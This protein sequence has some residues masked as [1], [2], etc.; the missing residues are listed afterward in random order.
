MNEPGLIEPNG[1]LSCFFFFYPGSQVVYSSL[2]RAALGRVVN[3]EQLHRHTSTSGVFRY[4]DV[5]FWHV[6]SGII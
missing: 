6:T 3:S 5:N 1:E 2:G 4:R